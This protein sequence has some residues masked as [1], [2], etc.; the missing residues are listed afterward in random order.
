MTPVEQPSPRR[1]KFPPWLRKRVP[2]AGQMEHVRDL[3]RDLNLATVCQSA[4]CP[5]LCECFSRGTA[6]F[7]I[8]GRVCTRNCRFCAVA[9]GPAAPPDPE[10]PG[11]V[12]E[13]TA[14]LNLS[15][16]VITSVTRDDLPDGGADH[17]HRTVK[18][19]RE[20]HDCTI[21]ILTPDFRGDAAA[22]DRASAARPDVYNH[23][24]ETVPRLYSS[25]RPDAD[26]RQSLDLLARAKNNSPDSA[27][28]SGIMVGLGE[29]AE[30]IEAVLRDLRAVGCDLLTVGQ[31]L[32]PTPDHHAVARYVTPEEFA[33]YEKLALT[34]GFAGVASGPFVRSS[35]RAGRMLD[36]FRGERRPRS[37]AAKHTG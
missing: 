1:S 32:Q 6:T 13:A 14:R 17:F 12:A 20:R 33:E 36:D 31:Y 26:Y 3:L 2:A 16:V 11:H 8:L 10:E 29:R 24:V 27:T 22:I 18:A 37:D 15:H 9:H 7:M 23:N 30:E 25:V 4:R 5:N 21:E 35:Y 19:V 34:L 28:K